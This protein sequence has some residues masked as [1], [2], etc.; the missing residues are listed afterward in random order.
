MVIVFQLYAISVY[1][2]FL[3]N[4]LPLDGG[5]NLNWK[6]GLVCKVVLALHGEKN[7]NIKPDS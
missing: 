5:G 3:R 1:E 4:A 7:I 2:S 6:R